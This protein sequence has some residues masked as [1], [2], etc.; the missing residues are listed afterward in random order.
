MRPC[1]YLVRN[2]DR[3]ECSAMAMEDPPKKVWRYLELACYKWPTRPRDIRDYPN[4]SFR[5]E[6]I[7]GD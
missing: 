3:Y 5:F 2:G 4:C 6:L 1:S 7:N